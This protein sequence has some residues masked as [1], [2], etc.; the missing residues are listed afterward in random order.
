A[1]VMVSWIIRFS[2]VGQLNSNWGTKIDALEQE[3]PKL[4][5][6]LAQ[7][8]DRLAR[9]LDDIKAVQEDG[10]RRRRVLQTAVEDREDRLADAQ[11]TVSASQ[12]RLEKEKATIASAQADRDLRAKEK[13]ET[14]KAL[15]AQRAELE[16]LQ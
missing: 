4:E 1:L 9:A 10:I 11:E 15:A 16:Q 5:A 7:E 3:K 12:I 6:G 14:E 8:G 13:V 2:M